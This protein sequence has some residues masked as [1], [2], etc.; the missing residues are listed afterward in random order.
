[1]AVALISIPGYPVGSISDSSAMKSRF[2]IFI[3]IVYMKS[4]GV[5][6]YYYIIRLS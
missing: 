6:W 1:M 3:F 4:L 5:I 2:G